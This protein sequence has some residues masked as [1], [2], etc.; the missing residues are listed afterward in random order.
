MYEDGTF[1]LDCTYKNCDFQIRRC[2]KGY[3]DTSFLNV[4]D[5]GKFEQWTYVTKEGYTVN[6]GLRNDGYGLI[7]IGLEDSFISINILPWDSELNEV[8]HTKAE[9]EELVEQMK[10]SKL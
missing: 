5:I 8:V 7:T 10:F 9:I 3:F 1:Q 6:C 4:G 2:M